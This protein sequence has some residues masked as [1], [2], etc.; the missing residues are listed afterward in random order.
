MQGRLV[1]AKKKGAN[2]KR[3]RVPKSDKAAKSDRLFCPDGPL[4]MFCRLPVFF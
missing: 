3:P 4:L 2:V 1:A